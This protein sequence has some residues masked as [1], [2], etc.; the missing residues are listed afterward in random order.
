MR[1]ILMFCLLVLSCTSHAQEVRV[2]R[3][4]ITAKNYEQPKSEIPEELIFTLKTEYIRDVTPTEKEIHVRLT[5][6][7]REE[8]YFYTTGRENHW[9]TIRTEEGV[10]FNRFQLSEA[11]ATYHLVS[12]SFSRRYDLAQVAKSLIKSKS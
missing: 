7:G 9:L 10:L 1:N 4:D 6:A 12:Q 5:H 3:P 8:L 11:L 2:Y